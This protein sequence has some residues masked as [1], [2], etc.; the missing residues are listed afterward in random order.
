MSEKTN[1]LRNVDM[2]KEGIGRVKREE[3]N[4]TA[5]RKRNGRKG[6]KNEKR[7]IY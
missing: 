1:G 5:E 7:G 2:R 6:E 3:R 4:R